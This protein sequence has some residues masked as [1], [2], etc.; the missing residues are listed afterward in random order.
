M[1]RLYVVEGRL[2]LTGSMADHR[3]R[4]PSSSIGAIATLLASKLGGA[5]PTG[6]SFAAFNDPTVDAWV[7]AMAADLQKAG[8]D[9]LVVC[10]SQQPAAVHAAVAAINPASALGCAGN[11]DF[12]DRRYFSR[13]LSDLAEQMSQGTIKTLLV[14]C[15]NPAFTAPTEL[16]FDELLGQVEQVIRL[17]SARGRNQRRRPPPTFRRSISSRRGATIPRGTAPIFPSSR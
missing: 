10:G 9:A 6:N 12:R 17:G 4:M 8:R 16:G 1:S 2:S 14:L 7:T 15:G 11:A 5:L 13:A 3:L